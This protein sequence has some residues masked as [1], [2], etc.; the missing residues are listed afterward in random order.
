SLT[1]LSSRA[2]IVPWTTPPS[3]FVTS[4]SVPTGTCSTSALRWQAVPPTTNAIVSALSHLVMVAPPP[5]DLTLQEV[6]PASGRSDT[7]VMN[8]SV[9]DG[10]ECCNESR[11]TAGWRARPQDV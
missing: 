9:S 1:S 3:C 6:C 10:K 2:L 8:F 4:T 5:R 7:F 11:E